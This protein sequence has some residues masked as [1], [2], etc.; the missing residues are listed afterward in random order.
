MPGPEII[1]KISWNLTMFD[2]LEIEYNEET[3]EYF[4]KL[5]EEMLEDLFWEEGDMLEWQIKNDGLIIH[6]L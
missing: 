5:S 3:D 4:I 2:E 1:Y 6:K